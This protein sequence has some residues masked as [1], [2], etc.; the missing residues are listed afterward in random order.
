[1]TT[2]T[3]VPVT[4]RRTVL[5]PGTHEELG[6]RGGDGGGGGCH[7]IGDVRHL[8]SHVLDFARFRDTVTGGGEGRAI[9]VEAEAAED[10]VV[11]EEEEE[12]EEEDLFTVYNE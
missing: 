2:V 7:K 5:A 9:L 12:E 1:M 6:G 11:V 8:V 10:V 4:G 3:T